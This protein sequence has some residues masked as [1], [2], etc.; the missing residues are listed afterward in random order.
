MRYCISPETS[1]LCH[2][3]QVSRPAEQRSADEKWDK[4]DGELPSSD[5][6]GHSS[7]HSLQEILQSQPQ[8]LNHPASLCA[9]SCM[10]VSMIVIKTN[11]VIYTRGESGLQHCERLFFLVPISAIRQMT[12]ESLQGRRTVRPNTSVPCRTIPGIPLCSAAGWW[13]PEHRAGLVIQGNIYIYI[14]ILGHILLDV[15]KVER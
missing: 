5:T 2:F 1:S 13:G 9:F 4:T 15:C 3:G 11:R 12:N 8:I 10:H 14:K 7:H 6:P